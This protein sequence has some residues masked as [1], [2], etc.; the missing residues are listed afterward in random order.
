M[1]NAAIVLLFLAPI[2]ILIY[3][4]FFRKIEKIN[5]EPE[6]DDDNYIDFDA[7]TRV[8]VIHKKKAS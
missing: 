5:E 8:K 2:V 4:A 1:Y 6:E 7:G 3:G